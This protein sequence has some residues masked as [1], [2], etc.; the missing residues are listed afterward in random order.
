MMRF[1][2]LRSTF[3][4][5]FFSIS[6]TAFIA[7]GVTETITLHRLRASLESIVGNERVLVEIFGQNISIPIDEQ[8]K[9]RYDQFI[10]AYRDELPEHIIVSIF[11]GLI[12]AI[13]SGLVLSRYLTR[14]LVELQSSITRIKV[15]TTVSK[16][17][18]SG[19]NEVRQTLEVFNS[20]VDEI[21]KQEQFRQQLISDISH[22]LKT[23]ITKIQGQVEG[24]LDDV[25]PLSKST[26]RSVL[27]DVEQLGHLIKSLY[28][29]NKLTP[30]E[31]QL[32]W[33]EIRI[34]PFLQESIE[35][36]G[37]ETVTFAI[38]TPRNLIIS[39]DKI[40]L[41]QIIG[42]L[43]S[44]ATKHTQNGSITISVD[45]DKL[46]IQDTGIGIPK[47][48]LP[49]IFERLYQVDSSRNKD[50]GG[51][52]LGLYIA[53]RLVELHGWRIAVSS[54]VKKGTTFTIYWK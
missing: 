53:K 39:A 25:Y 28:D 38:N 14:P 8:V 29:T 32:D 42:N 34:K 46:E 50:N 22:E 36:F 12:S 27:S 45:K 26:I 47:H 54:T 17:P 3:F 11:A 18:V 24:I 15:G 21:N 6:L 23:P 48:H 43:L 16:V 35:G 44:N 4:Q 31:T 40:R 2:F 30:Q 52:G 20:L 9:Y 51:L 33:S 10:Q 7:L 41:K 5:T 49:H 19:T 13:I 37:K 1:K